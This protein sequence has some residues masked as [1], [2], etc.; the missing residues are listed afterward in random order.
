MNENL[1][2]L[3]FLL[4]DEKLE[5]RYGMLVAAQQGQSV[6]LTC[7][8]EIVVRNPEDSAEAVAGAVKIKKRVYA[9]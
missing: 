2:H 3:S 8:G 7:R 5:G 4:I 9:S 1:K 6:D